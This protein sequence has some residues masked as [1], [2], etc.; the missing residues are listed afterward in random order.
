M[1]SDLPKSGD[2]VE[3]RAKLVTS[4]RTLGFAS[5]SL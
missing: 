2:E 3:I 1:P 4:G 5:A